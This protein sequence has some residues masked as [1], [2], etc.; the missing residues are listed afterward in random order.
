MKKRYVSILLIMSIVAA[1][2]CGSNTD[3]SYAKQSDE[4]EDITTINF[5][6]DFQN[7][8]G[9]DAEELSDYLENNG[10]DN[11]Q[12]VTVESDDTVS[13]ELT[14]DQLEYWKAYTKKCLDKETEELSDIEGKYYATYSDDYK[15]I[16]AY[17]DMDLTSEDA[18]G[19]VGDAAIY[20]AMYQVFN[21]ARDY[22]LT[23]NIFNV[24]TK[25]IVVGGNLET[26]DVSY[27]N[28]EWGVSYTL[29]DDEISTVIENA[30]VDDI[31]AKSTFVDGASLLDIFVTAAG[32][33]YTYL[34]LDEDG[35]IHVG[36]D[37]EQKQNIKNDLT[38]YLEQ[39]ESQFE[40]LG[41][42]YKI[43]VNDDYSKISYKFDS[44]LSKQEQSNYFI[45]SETVSMLL[46][47]INNTS[48]DFYIDISIYDSSTGELVSTGNTD[49]GI[50]W[51]IGEE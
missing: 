40:T 49:K 26:D 28:T 17:Y 51:N 10:E 22:D 50:T 8:A 21:G 48:P 37:N 23:L 39:I 3:A 30:D 38:D 29:S 6:S 36:L 20:C 27:D 25:K 16:N 14:D 15:E 11:Y 31:S 19:F 45:Y 32:D 12:K 13:M 43:D 41:D 7:L 46:Q 33:D 42:N 5:G 24:D 34:Y 18:F 1:S 2:G 9:M 4:T 44:Q 35:S 47:V